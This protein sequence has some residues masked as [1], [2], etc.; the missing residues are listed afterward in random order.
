MDTHPLYLN[1]CEC[2]SGFYGIDCTF[3]PSSNFRGLGPY[4]TMGHATTYC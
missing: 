1:V 4:M 3:R 2:D